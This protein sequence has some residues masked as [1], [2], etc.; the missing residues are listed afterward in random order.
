MIAR[1]AQASELP[2]ILGKEVAQRLLE[3]APLAEE[4][5]SNRVYELAGE[6]LEIQGEGDAGLL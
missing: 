3:V 5:S 2:A 6:V 1:R 4:N